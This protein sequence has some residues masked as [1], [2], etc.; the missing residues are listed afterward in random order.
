MK[1]SVIFT[2]LFVVVVGSSATAQ[3]RSPIQRGARV[4]VTAPELDLIGE[5]RTF[6]A[7][8]GDTIALD[9][10]GTTRIPMTSVTK[11]EV[12][13]QR[14]WGPGTGGLVGALTGALIG[15]AV[16]ASSCEDGF[17]F[18]KGACIGGGIFGLTM[19]GALLGVG[20]GALTASDPWM[21][22]PLEGLEFGVARDRRWEIGGSIRF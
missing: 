9:L 19:L 11:L 16:T 4:R 17:V 14:T 21:N 2:V 20:I 18:T 22:L 12:R 13:S 5:E 1:H 6:Y 8:A 15:I 3:S 7:W 10:H